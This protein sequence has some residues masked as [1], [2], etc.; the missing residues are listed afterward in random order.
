MLNRTRFAVRPLISRTRYFNHESENDFKAE[1]EKLKQANAELNKRLNEVK[2]DSD[3][4]TI[5]MGFLAFVGLVFGM[6]IL[7]RK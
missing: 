3:E 7:Q 1:I 2:N 6:T 4:N 5:N